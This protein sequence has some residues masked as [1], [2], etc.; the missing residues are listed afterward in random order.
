MRGDFDGD[1]QQEIPVELQHNSFEGNM[2]LVVKRLSAE[3]G[4]SGEVLEVLYDEHL[5]LRS[6]VVVRD[7]NADGVDDWVFV[8]GNRASG[9]GVFVEWGGGLNPTQ[10]EGDTSFGW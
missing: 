3:G 5:F 6:W 9:F 7:L 2:G 1:G 4:L 8:G 10:E